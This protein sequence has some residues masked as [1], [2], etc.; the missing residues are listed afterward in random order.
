MKNHVGQLYAG[1]CWEYPTY[2]VVAT[3]DENFS[4]ALSTLRRLAGVISYLE[5]YRSFCAPD[6]TMNLQEHL[7]SSTPEVQKT[8]DQRVIV[9]CIH[10]PYGRSTQ[11]LHSPS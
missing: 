4:S 7:L 3:Y 2:K 5:T 10:K 11:P 9:Q 8:E 1:P 6:I